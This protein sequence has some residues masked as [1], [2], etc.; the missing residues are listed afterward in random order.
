MGGYPNIDLSS[1]R[2]DDRYYN[3]KRRELKKYLP[4][5]KRYLDGLREFA[6]SNDIPWNRFV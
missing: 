2:R 6:N 1:H 3:K 5:L 4:K